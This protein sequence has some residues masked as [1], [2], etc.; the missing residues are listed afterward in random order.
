MAI[1]DLL[2]RIDA[3]TESLRRELKRA[4]A[5]VAQSAG[6]IDRALARIDK[7]FKRLGASAARAMRSSSL[8][9]SIHCTFGFSERWAIFAKSGDVTE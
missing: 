5:Q 2:L 6:K 9:W 1:E 8:V 3:S 7:S 4:D